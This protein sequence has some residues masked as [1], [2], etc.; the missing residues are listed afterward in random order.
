MLDVTVEQRDNIT[1]FHVRGI[2]SLYDEVL[3][4][5]SSIMF[6]QAVLRV[7]RISFFGRLSFS[8]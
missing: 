1:I 6:E 4:K 7:S 2:L 8:G 3:A 5:R